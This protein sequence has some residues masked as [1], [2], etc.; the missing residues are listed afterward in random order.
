MKNL[1]VTILSI[2]LSA[3][4]ALTGIFYGGAAFSQGQA[5]A[6]ANRIIAAGNQVVAALQLYAQRNG[7]TMPTYTE[8]TNTPYYS[9][10]LVSRY[11][12]A[13]P[14][15]SD[16]MTTTQSPYGIDPV[17]IK[18]STANSTTAVTTYHIY[19]AMRA[20][21]DISTAAKLA[22]ANK[23]CAQINSACVNST[24]ITMYSGQSGAYTAFYA[25]GANVFRNGNC[26]CYQ[27]D[28]NDSGAITAGSTDTECV[29]FRIGGAPGM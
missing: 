26:A 29:L 21:F 16:L 27:M 25:A 19:N 28:T 9:T 1:L 12:N 2:V 6:A 18:S 20:C 13:H 15:L 5:K 3:I 4:M 8:W 11:L 17:Y 24:T 10:S 22:K 7:G 14:N 23:I